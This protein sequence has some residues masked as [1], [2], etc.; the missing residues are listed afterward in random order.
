MAKQWHRA[1]SH[2]RRRLRKAAY[3]SALRW[4][5]ATLAHH[6]WRRHGSLNRIS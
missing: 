5:A 3:R 4:L 2:Q 6:Q 1:A